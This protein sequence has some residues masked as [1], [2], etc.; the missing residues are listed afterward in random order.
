MQLAGGVDPIDAI[1][2]L[3]E[4]V[5]KIPNVTSDPAPEVS[6]LEVNLVGTIAKSGTAEFL[7]KL[8]DSKDA[9]SQDLI[10]QFG[11]GFYSS[12]MVADKVTVVARPSLS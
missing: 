2:R 1:A 9:A 8:K 3:R 7:R 4:A 10:G 6:L 11:V 5:A 12:F